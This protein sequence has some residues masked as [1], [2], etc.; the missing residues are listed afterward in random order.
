MTDW[1]PPQPVHQMPRHPESTGQPDPPRQWL[2]PYPPSR[3]PLT[4]GLRLLIGSLAFFAF[5]LIV[6]NTAEIGAAF[7][8]VSKLFMEGSAIEEQAKGAII[9]GVL[10]VTFTVITRLLVPRQN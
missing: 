2:Y 8:L 3:R 9:L 4:T 7:R 6:N 10:C 5:L 1:R